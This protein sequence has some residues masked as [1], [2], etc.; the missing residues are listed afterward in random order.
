M[1][2]I[3]GPG[4]R[5]IGPTDKPNRT[6]K[7]SADLTKV[8]GK[9][10]SFSRPHLQVTTK[11]TTDFLRKSNGRGGLPKAEEKPSSARVVASTSGDANDVAIGTMT[12]KEFSAQLRKLPRSDPFDP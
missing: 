10:D 2:R 1:S 9:T 12:E 4:S 5:G 7:P 3:E 6:T 11:K 8:R